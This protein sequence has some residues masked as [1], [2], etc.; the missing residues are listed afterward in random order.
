MFTD[1]SSHIQLNIVYVNR[2]SIELRA[3]VYENLVFIYIEET[4]NGFERC[5]NSV[6][7]RLNKKVGDD[8]LEYLYRF[9][10]PHVIVINILYFYVAG[11]N[12]F[13]TKQFLGRESVPEG[14]R[15][16]GWRYSCGSFCIV[17]CQVIFSDQRV[18]QVRM[19]K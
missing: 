10:L 12:R 5:I 13:K 11:N 2:L 15:I 4:I 6:I 18:W 14:T 16:L 7:F 3:C 17:Y 8:V 19:S 1:I 9:T